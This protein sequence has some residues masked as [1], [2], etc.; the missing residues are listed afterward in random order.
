MAD[1][2]S[3]TGVD[4]NFFRGT[5][6]EL[7]ALAGMTMPVGKVG[8]EVHDMSATAQGAGQKGTEQGSLGHSD[9]VVMPPPHSQT[10]EIPKQQ[11]Q[12]Q[13][14]SMTY[15]V[16]SGDTLSSIAQNHSVSLPALIQANPQIANPNIIFPGQIVNIP[17]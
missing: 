13:P 5:E 2:G 9:P 14:S 15:V 6:E 1:D 3:S 10:Q 11:V 16:V 7:F 12:P 8:V 4:L 17:R